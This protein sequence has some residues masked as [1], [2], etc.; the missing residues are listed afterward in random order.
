MDFS[1]FTQPSAYISLVSLTFMEIVLGIDNIIFVAINTQRAA[2]ENQDRARR[3][4]LF[5]ALMIRIILLFFIQFIIES[6]QPLFYLPFDFE[7]KAISLKDIVLLLGGLFLLYKSTVEIDHK[8]NEDEHTDLNTKSQLSFMQV[9]IQ[10]A[11]INLVFSIDS[12]I[13]AIG[14][15]QSILIMFIS[16][17][18]SMIIMVLVSKSISAFIEKHPTVKILALS[19]LLMI[20]L[21][22]VA[23]AFEVHVPKGYVYF[24]MAFSL[25]VEFLNIK[26]RTK[27]GV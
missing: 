4:G 11:L 13:T 1:V 14:L 22:L 12:I 9:V 8:L 21:L 26:Y 10:I 2:P 23:E 20:G 19:F 17:V 7:G 3:W 5:M 24:A 15:T 27:K 18:L 16:I 25:G 6:T